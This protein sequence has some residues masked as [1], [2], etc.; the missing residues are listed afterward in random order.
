MED[1][2][3][4]PPPTFEEMADQIREDLA[5]ET[6]TH[7]IDQL[8]STAKIEKFN[9]DGSKPEAQSAKPAA[10]PAARRPPPPK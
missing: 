9:I 5:R 1:R 3:Q 2:R 10:P 6:V 7:F 8:R 4:A